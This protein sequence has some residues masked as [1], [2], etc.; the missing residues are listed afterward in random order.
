MNTFDLTKRELILF[1]ILVAIIATLLSYRFGTG[2]QIEDMPIV[3]RAIDDTFLTNDYVTNWGEEFGPRYYFAQFIAFIADNKT[4]PY[5]YLFL[6]LFTNIAITLVT[7][8]FTRFLFEGSDATAVLAVCLVMSLETFKL[9]ST[10]MLFVNQLTATRLVFPIL[11]FSV[12]MGIAGRPYLVAISAGLG[13]LLHVTFS[14]EV[15]VLAI[16]LIAFTKYFPIYNHNQEIDDKPRTRDLVFSLLILFS[17]LSISFS[18]YFSQEKIDDTLFLQIETFF[19]AP[20]HNLPTTFGEFE[21]LKGIGFFI[22]AISSWIWW[23]KKFNVSKVVVIR[24]ALLAV[25]IILLCFGGF[26]FVELYP[27][28]IWALARPFRL[29]ILLKW[30][31]LILVSGFIVNR[32]G[33]SKNGNGNAGAFLHL[34]STLSPITMGFMHVYEF[35]KKRY[36]KII[37]KLPHR[38]ELMILFSII[39]IFFALVNHPRNGILVPFLLFIFLNAALHYNFRRWLPYGLSFSV[40]VIIV[41]IFAPHIKMFSL[42]LSNFIVRIKPAITFE[43]MKSEE[44][45]ISLWVKEHTPS[46][47]IFLTPPNF[48]ILRLVGKRAIIADFKA[49]PMQDKAMLGWQKRLFDSYG[50]PVSSGFDALSEMSG[51]YE[52]LTKDRLRFLQSEYNISFAIL[53]K[54]SLTDE[55]SIFESEKYRIIRV[56]NADAE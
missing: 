32:L 22:A 15:G 54:N 38:L 1:S 11:L 46:D 6:T 34:L 2:N 45:K 5:I 29:L 28:R 13:S 30:F 10:S 42:P 47:A 18:E 41:L 52:K 23:K 21:Y 49:I 48:G 27:T 36:I 8:F 50:E 3:L 53:Y 51:N 43:E 12:W 56:P 31:G 26:I 37:E 14:S 24:I 16:M 19:R 39:M 25:F 4:L 17:F 35:V 55:P 7:V 40:V 33:N 44:A 9:G 20:H